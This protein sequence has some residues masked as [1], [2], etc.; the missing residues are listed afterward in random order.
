MFD[1]LGSNVIFIIIAVVVLIGRTVFESKRKK[2]PPPPKEKIPVHFIDE[3]DHIPKAA[4]KKTPKI[5]PLFSAAPDDSPF[6][7]IKSSIRKKTDI[8][9]SPAKTAIPERNNSLFN[10]DNL[11]PIQ[12]AVVMAEILG[13]PKGML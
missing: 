12:Q 10:L 11:S 13:P 8:P 1:S 6:S 5:T 2:K 3:E 9:K 4:V 7:P